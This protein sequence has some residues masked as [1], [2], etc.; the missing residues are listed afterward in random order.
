MLSLVMQ[1]RDRCSDHV[2]EAGKQDNLTDY[3][4][5]GEDAKQPQDHKADRSRIVKCN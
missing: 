2:D 5:E 3:P 1:I 4:T